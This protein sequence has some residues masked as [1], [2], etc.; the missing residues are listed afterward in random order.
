MSFSPRRIGGCLCRP[1]TSSA[2]VD[3]RVQ[4]PAAG[5]PGDEPGKG[6][7]GGERTIDGSGTKHTVDRSK[8]NDG[9]ASATPE[10]LFRGG[11]KTCKWVYKVKTRS[12]RSL[13][14]YKAC[15]VADGFQ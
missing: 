3:R 15:L 12:D 8:K 13:E 14:R 2:L 1:L 9:G 6:R 5:D 7:A 11:E 10:S 4:S